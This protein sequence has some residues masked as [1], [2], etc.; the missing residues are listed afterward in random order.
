MLRIALCDDEPEA[1][2]ALRIQLEKLLVEE[3]EEIVYEFSSGKNTV[4]WL[5]KH[6]GE[7]DL[8]FL[9]VEMKGLNG[10]ETAERIRQFDKNIVIVFVTGYTDYV[11]DG[12]HTGAW[13]YIIKPAAEQ[14]LRE[15][16]VRVRAKLDSE[17]EQVFILKNMDGTWRFRLCDT[18]YFYSDRRRC[19]LVTKHGEYPFYA[20]LDDIESRLAPRFIRIHQRYLVNP[21]NVDHVAGESVTLGSSQLPC[22]RKYRDAA[23]NKIAREMLKDNVLI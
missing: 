2:D 14:K 21:Q 18:L 9:D 22:S 3:V 5:E 17:K 4:S 1:R 7:I 23:M 20:K 10:V 13:D 12:Y 16:L 6:P 19:I 15:L 11:F 8:L